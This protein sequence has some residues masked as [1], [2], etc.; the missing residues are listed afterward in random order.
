MKITLVVGTR[1]SETD[2]FKTTATGRSFALNKPA[3]LKVR[4]FPNNKEG[5]SK[6]YNQAI[7]ECISNPSV[8]VF[9]HDDLHF[10]DYFWFVRV[11]E[12]LTQFEIVGL[13]GNLRRLPRQ[14]SW[15]YTG[16]EFTMDKLKYLSGVVGHGKS[17]PPSMLGKFGV[18][19]QRVKLLDGL[20]LAC[21]SETLIK[22]N[23]YFDERFDFHFYDLD[24][25]R[26]AESKD[27]SCGTWDLSL[28]HE[29]SGNF[30][31]ENW[32][33]SYQKYLEKWGD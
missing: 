27:I 28:I 21:E 7:R 26:Q 32:K 19:R 22:N 8:L 24:F 30:G 31:S 11:L 1:A 18:P 10:L 9:A 33:S 20:L 14:P 2:F 25:C 15:G 13:A 4:L 29:S 3:F 23:L 12:G 6:I 16:T 17:F 5:L